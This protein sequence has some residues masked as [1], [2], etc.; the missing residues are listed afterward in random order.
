MRQT[1]LELPRL[2]D[3]GCLGTGDKAPAIPAVP[4]SRRDRR[5]HSWL[6]TVGLHIPAW[7]RDGRDAGTGN[8]P[9]GAAPAAFLRLHPFFP[10]QAKQ[11]NP[12]PTPS[13]RSRSFSAHT[14][15]PLPHPNPRARS[16]WDPAGICSPSAAAALPQWDEVVSHR[17]TETKGLCSSQAGKGTP[18]N[19]SPRGKPAADGIQLSKTS[20]SLLP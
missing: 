5:Q 11:T 7:G 9:T 16:H 8:I 1:R 2:R 15:L 4:T 20:W 14:A 6:G 18:R 17:T 13:H 12:N 19:S 10:P 3:L